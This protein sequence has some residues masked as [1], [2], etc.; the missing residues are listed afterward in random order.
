LS[1]IRNIARS[2]EALKQGNWRKDYPNVNVI[3]EL[4]G[5]AIGIIGYGIIGQLVARF[6]NVFGT[7]FIFHYPYFYC[8]TFFEHVDLDTL[9]KESDIVTLHGTLTNETHNLLKE[10][11]IN[12]MKRTAILIN[13]S[14]T[15]LIKKEDLITALKN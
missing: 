2:H 9:L 11:H 5:R 12:M 1:E 3:P 7:R 10:K 6:I 8:D 15:G 14:R 4:E 13:T